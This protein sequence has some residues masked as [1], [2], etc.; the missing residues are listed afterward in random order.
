MSADARGGSVFF[1]GVA[2]FIGV[3]V[4]FLWWWWGVSV[5]L[6]TFMLVYHPR[7]LHCD[8]HARYVARV[9]CV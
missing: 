4:G 3:T 9:C 2:P 5:A 1:F 8:P 6:L 7:P